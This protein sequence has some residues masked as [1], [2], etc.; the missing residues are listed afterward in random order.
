MPS[1]HHIGIGGTGAKCVE[2]FVH[3]GAAGL[4]NPE[5]EVSLYDQDLGNGNLHATHHLL[6]LHLRLHQQLAPEL[7]E[8]GNNVLFGSELRKP[9]GFANWHWQPL[10]SA[11]GTLKQLFEFET[12]SPHL[13]AFAKC[14]YDENLELAMDLSQGFRGR[15]A[16]G[17]AVILA[18]R[19]TAHPFWKYVEDL[20]SRNM[21]GARIMLSGSVF[22]GTGAA[23]I[24]SLAKQ[25]RTMADSSQQSSTAIDIGAVLMLPYFLYNDPSPQEDDSVRNG[26]ARSG[27]QLLRS[28]LA[29]EYYAEELLKGARVF[30]SVYL[31]GQQKPAN[32]DYCRTGGEAQR[33]PPLLPELIAALGSAHFMRRESVGRGEA[34]LCGYHGNAVAWSD[35]PRIDG[36]AE[37]QEVTRRLGQLLRFAFAYHYVY[38]DYLFNPEMRNGRDSEEAWYRNLVHESGKRPLADDRREIADA[39]RRYC[40]SVL[41]WFASLRLMSDPLDLSGLSEVAGFAFLKPRPERPDGTRDSAPSIGLVPSTRTREDRTRLSEAFARLLG[42]RSDL[43]TLFEVYEGL[44]RQKAKTRR[45]FPAFVD[46]LWQA[47]ALAPKSAFLGS[48]WLRTHI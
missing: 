28:Q 26:M 18:T 2:A 3:L 6:D 34:L 5:I 29:L 15:P 9:K 40:Q 31:V 37:S 45:G 12:L 22:G 32:L 13:Q 23:G 21:G 38:H 36:R 20:L 24:P 8:L 27:T 33:N 10:D 16:V 7:R 43:P 46:A 4:T 42:N 25:L 14:L 11:S 1:Y 47:C 48:D 17:A 39:L 30:N 44:C 19:D 35:L 41:E